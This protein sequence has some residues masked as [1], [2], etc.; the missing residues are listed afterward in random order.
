VTTA[1][2]AEFNRDVVVGRNIVV[3]QRARTLTL[4]CGPAAAPV[5]CDATPLGI[6]A[7]AVVRS[8]A[9]DAGGSPVSGLQFAMA[10]AHVTSR[11]PAVMSPAVTPNASGTYAFTAVGVGTT[12]VVITMDFATDSVRFVV[13]P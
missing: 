1:I 9:R 11:N 4:A 8:S 2:A 10:R 7:A 13:N 3:G 12:W 5:A 6:G